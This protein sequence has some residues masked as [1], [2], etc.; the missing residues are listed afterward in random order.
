MTGLQKQMFHY[1][2][3]LQITVPEIEASAVISVDGLIIVSN[4]PE[5]VEGDR[6]SALSAAL[7]ALGIRISTELKRGSLEQLY[8]RGVE[9]DILLMAAGE[10]AVLTVIANR[11]AKLGLVLYYM[12]RTVRE[13]A[14]L[15]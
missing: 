5:E 7:L 8:I 9:G 6:V 10:T 3:K 2:R 13:L 14:V 1:L 4:L 12:R 15:L 11:Q